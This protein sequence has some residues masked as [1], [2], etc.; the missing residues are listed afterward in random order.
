ME[1]YGEGRLLQLL[2]PV[3]QQ[4]LFSYVLR[5][6]DGALDFFTCLREPPHLH[7][8]VSANAGKQ[9][10]AATSAAESLSASEAAASS[11]SSPAAGPCAMPTATARLSA[12]IGDGV[13]C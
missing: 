10:V 12:T 5:H 2:Q 8:Q 11:A 7:Q 6:C 4:F 1:L 9:M 13:I 3:R